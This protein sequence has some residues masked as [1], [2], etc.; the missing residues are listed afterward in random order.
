VSAVQGVV[1]YPVGHVVRRF[2]YYAHISYPSR[3]TMCK[4]RLP[5]VPLQ[6][7]VSQVDRAY[8]LSVHIVSYISHTCQGSRILYICYLDCYLR[9]N[10]IC[11]AHRAAEDT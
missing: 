5:W 6:L 1:A 11:R 10:H 7:Q 2:D 4:D 8:P 3:S 9:S